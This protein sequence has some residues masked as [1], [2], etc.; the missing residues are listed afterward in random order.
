M[1][2]GILSLFFADQGVCSPLFPLDRETTFC[3][4]YKMS[5]EYMDD[6]DIEDLYFSMGKPIFTSFKPDEMFS[7]KTLRNLRQGLRV[8]MEDYNKNSIFIWRLRCNLDNGS[9]YKNA[10]KLN[11]DSNEMPQPTPL[12]RSTL[13]A[14]SQKS[15]Y[16]ALE[17]LRCNKSYIKKESVLN[18]AIYL[19]PETVD[20]HPEKRNIALEEVLLPI[21][22]VIFRAIKME[23]SP[24]S[25]PGRTI[26]FDLPDSSPL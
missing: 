8:R 18:I 14:I 10:P 15:I 7:K 25:H 12:I 6:Q 1:L 21:R 3:L 2:G 4:F 17:R 26:S 24:L 11:V 5:G 9:P 23:V 13:S 16:R 20:Y 19:K 22:H